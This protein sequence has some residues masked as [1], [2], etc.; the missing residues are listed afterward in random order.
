MTAKYTYKTIPEDWSQVQRNQAARKGEI[1][2]LEV[3]QHNEIIELLGAISKGIDTLV[4]DAMISRHLMETLAGEKE[5]EP[6]S[7]VDAWY[8]SRLVQQ[9]L[10][11]D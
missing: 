5:K 6:E 11:S 8:K 4:A 2:S 10:K 1:E 9:G 7:P 3:T